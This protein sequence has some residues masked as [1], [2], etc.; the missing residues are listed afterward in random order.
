MR[1]AV[2]PTS[3][4]YDLDGTLVDAAAAIV[5]SFSHALESRGHPPVARQAVTSRIGLPL[6]LMFTDLVEGSDDQESA[7]LVRSYRDHYEQVAPG[8]L[9]ATPGAADALAAFVGIP[10][11]L[12]TTKA[13]EPARFTL[14]AL[15][16]ESYF[17]AIVG[18]DA[19]RRPKPDPEPVRV[20]LARLG[21]LP[22][23]SAIM[24]GD[25][26]MDVLA[27]QAAGCRTIAV[28]TGHGDRAELEAAKPDAIIPD[29]THFATAVESL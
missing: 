21:R 7:A 18:V 28:L 10:H 27:G 9:Q 4:L 14:A 17:Q 6:R 25:T 2:R 12:V 5:A 8:L 11:A 22:A 13:T 26:I 29:L 15:G 19:V 16:F 24:V 1:V 3:I 23:K 20:A